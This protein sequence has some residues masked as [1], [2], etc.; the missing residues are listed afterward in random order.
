MKKQLAYAN[1]KGFQVAII[2]GEEEFFHE[3]KSVVLG[4]LIAGV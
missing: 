2:A 4:V 1:R 3:K